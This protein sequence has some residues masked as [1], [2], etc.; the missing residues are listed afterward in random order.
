MPW[1]FDPERIEWIEE[2]LGRRIDLDEVGDLVDQLIDAT[3]EDEIDELLDILSDQPTEEET[4]RW[5]VGFWALLK[6]L[7]AALAM[8]A[9]AGALVLEDWES[10]QFLLL[11]QLEHLDRFA[12]EVATGA[13]SKAEAGRRMRMYVNSARS[14]FWT[15]LDRQMRDAGYTEERWI[16]I[17]DANTCNPCSDADGMG[18]QP[19]GTFAEPG[20]GYVLRNPT[21]ECA[22][23]SSCRCRKEYRRRVT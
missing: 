6:W 8:V 23:L 19:I 13:V 10:V 22:G 20:S 18:W 11:F 16:A 17:G 3:S 12:Q 15:V 2:A 21:T 14:A 9:A 7:Y 4:R 1:R 5:K